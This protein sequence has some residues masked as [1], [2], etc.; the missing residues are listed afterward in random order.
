MTH[1]LKLSL[2]SLLLGFFLFSMPAAAQQTSTNESPFIKANSPAAERGNATA[3]FNLGLYYSVV[4][5]S[6]PNYEEAAKWFRMAADQG[7]PRAQK[8]LCS[9]YYSGTGVQQDYNEAF[10]LCQKAANAGDTQAQEILGIMYANGQ[11]VQQDYQEASFWLLLGVHTDFIKATFHDRAN[12]LLS[13]QHLDEKQTKAVVER[14]QAW[15]PTHAPA[16]KP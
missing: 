12:F 10:K 14:V 3:Q 7:D 1:M 2:A 11:G 13:P 15:K 6:H 4:L 8:L 16:S 9:F 5:R